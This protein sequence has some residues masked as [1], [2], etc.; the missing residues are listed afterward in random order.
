MGAAQNAMKFEKML[1]SADSGPHIRVIN[2]ID[3]QGIPPHF[4]YIN[5]S[6][7]GPGVP[8]PDPSFLY[9]CDCTDGC[10]KNANCI[11]FENNNHS[12]PYDESLRLNMDHGGIYE[13]N[14]MCKCGPNCKNRVVQKGRKVLLDLVRFSDGRGWGVIA[15]QDIPRG[16]FISTYTGEVITNEEADERAKIYD[17]NDRAYL[18]DLDFFFQQ[19]AESDFTIDARQYGNVSHFFNHSCEPNIRVYACFVNNLDPRLHINAFFS[20]KDIKKGD[21]VAFDYLGLKD[22]GVNDNAIVKRP[23]EFS[24]P[25]LCGSSKCRK[26]VYL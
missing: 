26:Y 2:E 20:C 23:K 17:L 14:V 13:C 19:G 8:L 15:D 11:C 9:G 12:F 10:G 24:L 3:E 25:C 4:T 22:D 1:N 6:F 7:F 21:E 16:T 5:E 18:F